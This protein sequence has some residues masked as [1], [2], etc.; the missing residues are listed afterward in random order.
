MNLCIR[1]I[2]VAAAIAL[3]AIGHASASGLDLASRADQPAFRL[4][5]AEADAQLPRL[6][7]EYTPPL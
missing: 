4:P 1:V 7:D 3:T 2:S 6:L 5:A